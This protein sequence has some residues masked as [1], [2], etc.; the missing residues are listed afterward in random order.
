[1]R[2]HIHKWWYYS[3]NPKTPQRDNARR[4]LVCGKRQVES[5]AVNYCT[6]SKWSMRYEGW[7]ERELLEAVGER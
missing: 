4:C 3:D 5:E 2:T 1:M 6:E 7:V